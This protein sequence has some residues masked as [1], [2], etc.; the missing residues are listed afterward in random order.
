MTAHKHDHEM[1]VM[2]S[3]W[4]ARIMSGLPRVISERLLLGNPLKRVLDLLALEG[5]ETVVDSAC[6]SGYYTLPLAKEL[7]TGRVEAVDL[8]DAMLKRLGKRLKRARL[9]ERVNISKGDCEALPLEAGTAQAGIIIAALHHLDHPHK[10]MEE[11]CRVLEPGGRVVAVDW[12]PEVHQHKHAHKHGADQGHSEVNIDQLL[13]DAGFADIHI[14][15]RRSWMI[16]WAR[17]A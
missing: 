14:E 4:E 3:W 2:D 13:T 17:K 11:L 16:G 1:G 5:D 7:S 10:A 15:P 6:G 9:S 8:S 12:N